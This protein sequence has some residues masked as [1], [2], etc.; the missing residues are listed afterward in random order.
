SLAHLLA[1]AYMDYTV[2]GRVGASRGN[3]SAY[4]A[5]HDVYPCRGGDAWCAI[6]VETDAQWRGMAAAMGDP[7]WAADPRFAT[8]AGRMAHKA[9]LDRLIGGWTSDL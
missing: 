5:P 3:A 7:A 6:A 1:V 4:L 9:D 2:N 8:G